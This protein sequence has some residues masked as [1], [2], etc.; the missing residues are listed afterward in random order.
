MSIELTASRYGKTVKVRGVFRIARDGEWHNTVEYNVEAL[1]E[2][3]IM[4]SYTEADNSRSV[5]VTTY[6]SAYEVL[7]FFTLELKILAKTSPYS[8]S[9]YSQLREIVAAPMN[10][11]YFQVPSRCQGVRDHGT[12]QCSR[13]MWIERILFIAGRKYNSNSTSYQW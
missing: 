3:K 6:S 8:M 1:L 13:I 12:A 9:L 2:N 4:T 10:I 11:F 5:V 7:H